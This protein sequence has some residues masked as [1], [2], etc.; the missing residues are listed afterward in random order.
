MRKREKWS[1][2]LLNPQWLGG[3]CFKTYSQKGKPFLNIFTLIYLWM[4]ATHLSAAAVLV[5][6]CDSLLHLTKHSQQNSHVYIYT[7][8]FIHWLISSIPDS[9]HVRFKWCLIY[10]YIYF[11]IA[12]CGYAGAAP[13][14]LHLWF[15][16]IPNGFVTQMQTDRDF[17]FHWFGFPRVAFWKLQ[18]SFTAGLAWCS[19]WYQ[20]FH[21]GPSELWT[22]F[23]L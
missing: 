3:G 16:W 9:H 8:S 20:S 14:L 13:G 22:A 18:T 4:W 11:I 21:T 10:I 19:L 5:V 6:L 23:F 15:E 2:Q 12:L 17:I 7:S 1:N